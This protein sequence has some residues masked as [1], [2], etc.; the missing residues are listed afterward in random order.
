[1]G[2]GSMWLKSNAMYCLASFTLVVLSTACGDSLYEPRRASSLADAGSYHLSLVAT[3]PFDE[4]RT[5]LKPKFDLTAENAL[6]KVLPPTAYY[7]ERALQAFT[8]ALGVGFGSTVTTG[9]RETTETNGNFSTSGKSKTEQKPGEAPKPDQSKAG[10]SE[11]TVKDAILTSEKSE[12]RPTTSEPILQYNVATALFQEV[13][14]LEAYLDHVED[15]SNLFAYIVRLNVS[16]QPFARNQPYDAYVSIGFFPN[17]DSAELKLPT[18]VPLFVTDSIEGTR[19]ARSSQLL[20]QVATALSAITGGGTAISGS[21]SSTRDKLRSISG[22]DLNATMTVSRATDNVIKV[23]LGA[24]QQPSAGFTMVPRNHTISVLVLA[25]RTESALKVQAVNALRDVETGGLVPYSRP[26]VYDPARAAIR[27]IL[28]KDSPTALE[29]DQAIKLLV[30]YIQLRDQKAFRDM[31][32][33]A[34]GEKFQQ[35]RALWT[36]LSETSSAS[37]FQGLALTLPVDRALA[38]FEERVKKRKAPLP[39]ASEEPKPPKPPTP[40]QPPQ[41]TQPAQPN[42]P[43][44]PLQPPQPLDIRRT[45]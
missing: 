4:V 17:D 21:A 11:A 34:S 23:R 31:V 37:E 40:V 28:Q 30:S 39:R 8:A 16:L 5:T 24:P 15:S 7:E 32:D 3:I 35:W 33:K 42:Q 20:T 1:M 45:F 22:T 43:L 25:Q 41:P 6:Q 27:R 19:S 13:R 36:A 2:W 14:L 29:S 44:Q 38:A 10:L 12:K 9:S 18:V 26:D